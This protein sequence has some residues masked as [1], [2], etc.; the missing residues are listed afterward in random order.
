MCAAWE[1]QAHSREMSLGDIRSIFTDKILSSSVKT[2]NITGGEPTLRRDLVDIVKCLAGCC[3]SLERI[4]IS[5]NGIN[6]IEVVDKIEQILGYLLETNIRLGVSISVDGVGAVHDTIRGIPG[7]FEKIDKTI[8]EVR[9]FLL[10]YPTFTMG[11]NATIH[12][13]NCFALEDILFYSQ[14]KQVGISFTLAALSDIGVE[15]LSSKNNFVLQEAERKEVSSFISRLLRDRQIN[16]QYGHFLIHW[17][18]TGKRRARC[19]FQEGVSLLC[20]PDGSVYCC[21]N[22][23]EFKIGNVLEKSFH[24]LV[25]SKKRLLGNYQRRCISCNSNCYID[26]V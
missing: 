5:T 17:L 23:K 15:S 4:D 13:G 8:D 6:T 20:E 11:L 26:A 9:D 24:K 2:V 19:A 12:K 16:E 22:F 21:G 25:S 14:K 10:L 3:S 1:K 18:E 7:A